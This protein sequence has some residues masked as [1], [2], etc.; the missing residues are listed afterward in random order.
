MT[1]EREIPELRPIVARLT[2]LDEILKAFVELHKK[3]I[4]LLEQIRAAFPAP[5]TVPAAPPRVAIPQVSI[6]E[7]SINKLAEAIT[8]RLVRLPNRLDRIEID[9]SNTNWVS[10]RKAGKIKPSVALGFWVEDIGGGFDY[11]ILRQGKGP[12]KARTAAKDDKWDQEFD[13]LMVKGSGTS[14]TAVIYYWWREPL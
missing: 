12:T 7:I 1:E 11:I 2:K 6:S 9:T 3:E 13:D 5:P 4:E 14:G 8:A 10:L